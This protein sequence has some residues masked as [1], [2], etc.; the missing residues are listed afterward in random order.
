MKRWLCLGLTFAS[1]WRAAPGQTNGIFADFSTSLG[2]FT[3]WLDHERAPRAVASFVGLATGETGWLD[4][5][6]NVWHRPFYDG[7]LFHRIV[8]TVESNEVSVWTNG[9]AIQ[10]GG[11]P[12][13]SLATSYVPVDVFTNVHLVQLATTNAVGIS[14]SVLTVAVQTTNAPAV[15]TNYVTGTNVVVTNAPKVTYARIFS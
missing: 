6:S 12:A 4:L 2:E 15:A 7:S 5:Q 3:V 9:I 10:G 8:K 14:T 1:L 13:F 11:V